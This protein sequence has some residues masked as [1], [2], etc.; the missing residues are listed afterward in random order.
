MH[1]RVDERSWGKVDINCYLTEGDKMS[2][3]LFNRI[4]SALKEV[5]D[6][7]NSKIADDVLDS[8]EEELRKKGVVE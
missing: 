8:V 6:D 2:E 3:H 4:Y 1:L 5:E 7:I